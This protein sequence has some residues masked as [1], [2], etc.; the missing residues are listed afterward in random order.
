MASRLHP[1]ELM[2]VVAAANR[3]AHDPLY[4]G[5]YRAELAVDIGVIHDVTV[6]T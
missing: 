1:V 2:K 4:R 3:L 6:V 5:D